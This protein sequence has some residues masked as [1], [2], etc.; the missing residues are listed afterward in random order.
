MDVAFEAVSSLRI[1]IQIDGIR[2]KEEIFEEIMLL[3]SQVQDEK[4]KA[5]NSGKNA[6]WIFH[7]LS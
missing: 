4:G 6:K 7:E 5:F 1:N 3:L 2:P